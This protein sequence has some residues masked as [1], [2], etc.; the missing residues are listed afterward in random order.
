MDQVGNGDENWMFD[1]NAG[2]WLTAPDVNSEVAYFITSGSTA[3]WFQMRQ[4]TTHYMG[5][6]TYQLASNG[7]SHHCLQDLGGPV[8]V[9]DCA[10]TSGQYWYFNAADGYYL[11]CNYY[12]TVHS[13]EEPACLYDLDGSAEADPEFGD[14]WDLEPK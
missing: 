8:T 5:F 12:W 1:V 2:Q 7:S 11:I 14:Y 13:G 4:T 3:T 6:A 9:Q 10:A